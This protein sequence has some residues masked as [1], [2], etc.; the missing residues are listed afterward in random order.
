MD[1]EEKAM[2]KLIMP[3]ANR[4]VESVW[5]TD[6]R[7]YLK[8]MFE[9][10]GHV[11]WRVEGDCCSYTWIEGIENLGSKG[12]VLSITNDG[13]MSGGPKSTGDNFDHVRYYGLTLKTEYGRLI[14]DYRN[15][16]NGYYGGSMELANVQDMPGAV[17]KEVE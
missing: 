3:F 6:N 14:I 4:R 11:Y 15:D 2:Q 13:A 9:D 5:I 8:F 10:G 12:T 7:R 17:W 16:S 1:W